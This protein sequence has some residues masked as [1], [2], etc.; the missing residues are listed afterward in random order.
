MLFTETV[1]PNTLGVLKELMKL[2]VL[3][4][5]ALVGGTNLSLKLGHRLSVDL[6]IL[7]MKI[8]K[9]IVLFLQ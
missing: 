1:E 4:S 6:D 7:V 9:V 5:F 8:L 3:E 2:P